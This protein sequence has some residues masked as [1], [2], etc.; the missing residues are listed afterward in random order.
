MGTGS[1]IVIYRHLQRLVAER[2]KV[3]AIVERGQDTSACQAAGIDTKRLP[4]RKP[5]WPP[6]QPS[7]SFSRAL[8]MRLWAREARRV[9]RKAE[10]AICLSYLSIHSHDMAEIAMHYSRRTRIPLVTIVHDDTTAFKF[11]SRNRTSI[12]KVHRA[13]LA[14]SKLSL[15]V[16]QELSEQFDIPPSKKRVLLPIPAGY[17]PQKLGYPSGSEFYYA[18]RV[19]THQLPLFAD[20]ASALK[21]ACCSLAIIAEP[22]QE[23]ESFTREHNIRLL[24]LFRTNEE[25]LDHLSRFAS[26]IIVAYVR[27]MEDMEWIRT[28]FPSKLLEYSHLRR[29]ICVVSPADSSVSRYLSQHG[30]ELLFPPDR[31]DRL[32]AF[33]QQIVADRQQ[34]HP[35]AA[36]ER[37]ASGPFNP[38][39][40]HEQFKGFLQEA[41][42][43]P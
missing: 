36:I 10:P 34:A 27:R 6:Y 23:L 30:P 20:I 3:T 37:L 15:F 24:P 41:V 13:I 21:K 35:I 26:G 39:T 32:T 42:A 33:A 7:S 14:S 22:T 9:T 16:S 25:A 5:W 12:L 43:S 29:P 38:D 40:I 18:G 11:S 19:W 4:L 17:M 1:P 8:R 2:W 28:S 31:L